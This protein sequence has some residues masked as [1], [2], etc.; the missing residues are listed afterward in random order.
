[1]KVTNIG[2]K[3]V[4]FYLD[5]NLHIIPS[6]GFLYIDDI[7]S[8]ELEKLCENQ[9][10]LKLDFSQKPRIFDYSVN[11]A[12][13][14][15]DHDGSLIFHADKRN[16]S[17]PSGNFNGGGSGNKPMCGIVGFDG[18]HISKLAKILAETEI[19][20]A[21]DADENQQG[22]SFNVLID[23]LGLGNIA[24]LKILNITNTLNLVTD[25]YGNQGAKASVTEFDI[26]AFEVLPNY[27]TG[28]KA[29]YLKNHFYIVGGL[30]TYVNGTNFRTAST[31]D[32]SWPGIP[33]SLDVLLN[34][35]TM[36]LTGAQFTS[37]YPN[38]KMIGIISNDGGHPAG[39]KLPSLIAQIGG[40][41]Q[42]LKAITAVTELSIGGINL[43][44]PKTDI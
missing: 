31:I 17:Q 32:N 6:K 23:L 39:V 33:M 29:P 10:D 14:Y 8:S 21:N 24:D 11:S 15:F 27:T 1:M 22:L 13:V 5:N 38:C 34:G 9:T 16:T 18:L 2:T 12:K 42:A 28:E 20:T 41:G 40:S 43:L 7:Y 3:Q 44:P 30:S 25:K 4:S 26:N 19:R 35:G 37:G 36:P